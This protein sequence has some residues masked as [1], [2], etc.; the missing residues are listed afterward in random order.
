MM[1]THELHE[2]VY[3][4]D[5]WRREL[6]ARRRQYEAELANDAQSSLFTL[7]LIQADREAAAKEDRAR[8]AS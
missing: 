6:R 5:H 7:Y 3:K 1:T 8:A 4:L 2:I